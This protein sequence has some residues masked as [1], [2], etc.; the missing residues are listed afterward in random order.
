[1]ALSTGL[2]LI[3]NA[4]EG[5]LQIGVTDDENPLCFEEWYAPRKATEIL[6]DALKEIFCRVGAQ[7]KEFR[8]VACV[9]GPGSFTGIRLVLAFAAAMRR[10]TQV[11]LA[12]LDYLQALATQAAI[13][14]GALY[15][16]K[17]YVLTNA[18]RD[19]V[20][21]RKF[22][23]YGPKIPAQPVA[24]LE[25][26]PPAIALTK[27]RNDNGL[28]CGS[29][30]DRYPDLFACPREGEGPPLAP[31][32]TLLPSLILPGFASLRLLARHGDYFPKDIEPKYARR[33]DAEENL[34][35]LTRAEGRDPDLARSEFERIISSPPEIQKN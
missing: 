16:T 19:L 7:P 13:M 28:V 26:I 29:A 3:L 2:E 20:H 27:M 32:L 31:G 33:C 23:S 22:I 21:F 9:A 14:R 24:E 35:E 4:C 17:I 30:I 15:P 34:E 25:L 6:A 10:V 11:Q 12:S 5:A 18:K 8:R 1:M